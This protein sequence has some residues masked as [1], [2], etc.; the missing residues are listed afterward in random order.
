MVNFSDVEYSHRINPIQKKYIPDLAAASET[1]STLLAA[2]NKGGGDKKGGSEAF[3]TNS[4]ENFLAAIMYFSS[5]S[6]LQDSIKGGNAA[7]LYHVVVR[8][9]R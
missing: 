9:L 6:I 5:I 2:L 3:F 4:A 7:G 1:A 8:S